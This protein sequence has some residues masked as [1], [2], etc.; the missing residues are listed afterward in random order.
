MGLERESGVERKGGRGT[1]EER[2]D[3]ERQGVE[4]GVE[5]E[6][7]ETRDEERKLVDVYP[8]QCQ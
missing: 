8:F 6:R 4:S 1:G 5:R 3:L 7:V 2:E